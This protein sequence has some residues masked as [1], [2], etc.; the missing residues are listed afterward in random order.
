METVEEI[1]KRA[2]RL[3]SE[4]DKLKQEFKNYIETSRKNEQRKKQEIIANKSKKLLVVADSLDRISGL[5]KKSSCDTASDYSENLQK[6]IEV[7]YNQMLSASDLV[8]INPT[9]GDIFD[10]Q[11]HMA[12]GLEYGIAYPDNS[13]FRVIRKGYTFEDNVVRPAEVIVIKTP[14]DKKII[15]P[16]LWTR[17]FRLFRPTKYHFSDINQKINEIDQRQKD[18]LSKLEVDTQMLQDAIN[19]L[20]EKNGRTGELGVKQEELNK[21]VAADMQMLQDAI[22]EL[23]EK[24]GRT[25]ELGAKQEELN[26]RVAADMQMLQDAINELEE[27]N[28]RTG[29]LGAK[30]EELNKRVAADMQMLQDAINELEVKN[31]RTGELGAKQEELNKRVAADMGSLREPIREMEEMVVHAGEL[32]NIRDE[33]IEELT[34]DIEFLIDPVHGMNNKPVQ[35]HEFEPSTQHDIEKNMPDTESQSYNSKENALI[36]YTKLNL[37]VVY[38]VVP[39]IKK[40]K[41]DENEQHPR[42]N[43][44]GA[45]SNPEN[46]TDENNENDENR[47][48]SNK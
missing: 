25:G 1:Q 47:N 42:F 38:K 19:E 32:E 30:Q 4:Y 40:E 16:G 22:N 9:K 20:E 29:E 14:V 17:L 2:D 7:V 33:N 12:I 11:K 37:P 10:E 34:P 43:D 44:E 15:K 27:K 45:G 39:A 48:Y 6:N 35:N 13:I 46:Y 21:R 26:K 31:G 23:E 5:D 28:G 36:L 41:T 18:Y 3:E 8:S 24:N